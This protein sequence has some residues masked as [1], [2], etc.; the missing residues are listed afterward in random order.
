MSIPAAVFYGFCSGSLAFINKLAV[1]TFDFRY[2]AFILFAQMVFTASI[3][4]ILKVAGK[5]N[6]A[7][8][9]LESSWNCAI[10]S[11]FYAF[12]AMFALT[13]LG[14]LNIPMYNVIKRCVPLVNIFLA[15]CLLKEGRPSWKIISTVV[16]ITSGCII[17]GFGD[18]DFSLAAYLCGLVSIFSQ[19]LYL[20][21]VQKLGIEK[22]LTALE[23][24]YVNSIN[25]IPLFLL[26]I[27]LSWEF[28]DAVNF[29]RDCTF[30]FILVFLLVISMGCVLNYSLFLCTTLNSALTTSIVGVIKSVVTTVIGMF[31][32]GG[33][34]PTVLIITGISINTLGGMGYT[35]LKYKE[36]QEATDLPK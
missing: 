15:S 24:L 35:Y 1:T 9:S 8:I 18:L 29:L 10:P 13:A 21:Y 32:F 28:V 23:L 31:T 30:E 14:D 16:V 3:L 11:L 19:G 33:I 7:G 22:Q 34:Q 25:C 6:F 17:A 12:H 5:I 20:T 27:L 26:Y 36:K 4:K 2:P